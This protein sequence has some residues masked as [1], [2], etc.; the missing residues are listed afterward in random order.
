MTNCKVKQHF[1]V[2]AM[3]GFTRTTRGFTRTTEK[4]FV[5]ILPHIVMVG[6]P[7]ISANGFSH[8]VS[9]QLRTSHDNYKMF[10]L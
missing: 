7:R 6:V 4:S 1:V 9:I 3:L 8:S 10:K 2:K 5:R